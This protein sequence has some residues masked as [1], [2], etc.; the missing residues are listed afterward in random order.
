MS[1]KGKDNQKGTRFQNTIALLYMLDSSKWDN[2]LKIKLEGENHED[3]TLFFMDTDNS[4]SFF[5]EFEVKYR[6][7]RP[8]TL[9]DIREIVQKEV[10]KGMSRYSDKDRF[11]IIASSFNK[12]SK[13]DMQSFKSK[14]FFDLSKNFNSEKAIYR[15]IYGKNPILNWSKE[16]IIFIQEKVELIEID[17]NSIDKLIRE[18]FIYEQS[19]FYTED[20][21]QNIIAR[22]F[23]KITE[24]ST[25]GGEVTKQKIKEIITNFCKAE[26]EKSESY[27]LDKDLGKI[28][29][30]I[31][32]N[33]KTEDD[34]LK[35]EKS[36]APISGRKNAVIYI[37]K[38]LEKKDFKFENIKWFF[39]K[40][41]IKNN[42]VF[43]GLKLIKK[44]A[45]SN[46]LTDIEKTHILTFIFKLYDYRPN[47][48]HFY[49][50]N[51]N[52]FYINSIFSVI[53]N[54]SKNTVS[55][56]IK[57]K[58]EKFLDHFLP[59]WNSPNQDHINH[60]LYIRNT[61]N[62]VK[63]IFSKPEEGIK[64][65]FKKYDFTETTIYQDKTHY[66]YIQE[67]INKD[68][69]KNFN[70][71]IKHLA[72][73]FTRLHQKLGYKDSYKGYELTGGYSGSNDQYSLKTFQWEPLLSECITDFYNKNKDIKFLEAIIRSPVSRD[74]PV[75][76]KRSCIPLLLQQ[77]MNSAEEKNLKKNKW[78]KY[79]E[80]I[81]EIKGGFP[82]TEEAVI[83]KLDSK[84]LEVPNIYLNGIV[85]K[86]L[87][88][89]SKTG[90]SGNILIIQFI[91][92]LISNGKYQFKKDLKRI[93]LDE[94]FK[95][96]FTYNDTLGVLEKK[97]NNRH[98]EEFFTEIRDNLDLSQNE[99][100]FYRGITSP[101][102][103]DNVEKL[104]KS[105]SKKELDT[106]AKMIG[107][108]FWDNKHDFIKKILDFITDEEPEKFYKRAKAS[109]N[110]IQT[111]AQIPKYALGLKMNDLAESIIEL[112]VNDTDLYNES[113]KLH[114][115]IARKKEASLGLSIQTMRAHLCYSIDSYVRY[116]C[117]KENKESIKKLEKAFIWIKK[118]MDMDGSLANKIKDF[119]KPNYY[120]RCFVFIP[121]VRL[122]FYKVQKRPNERLKKLNENKPYLGDE[123]K[124]FSFKILEQTEKEIE[125]NKYTPVQ[126]LNQ[127][128]ALMN[129][130]RDLSEE[131]VKK[132]LSFIKKFNITKASHLF[133]YYALYRKKDLLLSKINF[134]SHDFKKELEEIC[135]NN[136]FKRSIA[137][138]MYKGVQNEKE[139][140]PNPDFEFFET[141]K[142]YWFLL[143]DHFSKNMLSH[144]IS[145]LAI[146]LGRDQSYYDDHKKYLFKLIKKILNNIETDGSDYFLHLEE[147]LQAVSKYA[148]DDLA[149]ILILF[150]EKGD[151]ATGFIPFSFEVE[152]YLIPE[153]KKQKD[154]ISQKNINKTNKKLSALGLPKI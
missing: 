83:D 102:K 16:E 43:S 88:K 135:K 50:F 17:G 124:N 152:H 30:D 67:F 101:S 111:T 120:L 148:P 55:D 80:S 49:Q 6:S 89:Y 86:I 100:L 126:L 105:S 71:I 72:D 131:E 57:K 87:Y 62:I 154:N 133:I 96:S 24:E 19:F 52:H 1:K 70:I 58:V 51:F 141:I 73:Q 56:E 13:E 109:E 146:V 121:L 4:S 46:N 60:E 44:Y 78:Y 27:S 115:E 95:K 66:N 90:I 40:I 39:D 117:A 42:Y 110:L 84:P 32:K 3:F 132:V 29:K 25:R 130:I 34:F 106:L 22:L 12:K 114:E 113:Q 28:K 107:I 59:N 128:G 36:L 79:L 125:E 99:V 38:E 2:F 116:Y 41:L 91:M 5:Y 61:P 77:L 33:L 138:T 53:L 85:K 142:K 94:E 65:I 82:R 129:I 75:F 20:N 119:P 76:T 81:I 136:S 54:L 45:E 68:F 48:S 147:A 98:I 21:A 64:F 31:D 15:E 108:S 151:E 11:F 112:C 47:S 26:T 153:I 143:F 63:N 10:K 37:V 149:E 123:I 74:N 93:L 35:L 122:S 7:T 144:L 14:H 69:K 134:E 150:L 127:I 97:I 18:R 8:L 140:K 118:L 145:T 23:R 92:H 104:F 103:R 139:N 137:F 9:N